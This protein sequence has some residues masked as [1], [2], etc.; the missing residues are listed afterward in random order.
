MRTRNQDL[1]TP[2]TSQHIAAGCSL[3]FSIQ[4][5]NIV[6]Y[7]LFNPFGIKSPRSYRDW[8]VKPHKA[9]STVFKCPSNWGVLLPLFS[10]VRAAITKLLKF[11]H[12]KMHMC[13]T[14]LL[15]ASKFTERDWERKS[16]RY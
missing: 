8:Q 3:R 13:L 2:F 1:V 10:I 16:S 11:Y 14:E 4:W 12:D 9:F 5:A 7:N 6:P 15:T